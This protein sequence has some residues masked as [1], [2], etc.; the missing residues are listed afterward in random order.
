MRFLLHGLK[1]GIIF[2]GMMIAL[3]C[4]PPASFAETRLFVPDFRFGAGRDT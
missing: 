4:L 3:I 1:P 2:I